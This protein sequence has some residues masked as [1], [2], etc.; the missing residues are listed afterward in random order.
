MNK[1]NYDKQIIALLGLATTGKD[2]N[3]KPFIEMGF[4]KIAF[5]DSLRK[6]LWDILGY[7]PDGDN[8]P[9]NDFK[10]CEFKIKKGLFKSESVTTVRKMLQNTGSVFK[11]LFGQNYWTNL[12]VKTA[13]EHDKIVVTDTR[14][15]YEIKKIM[16]LAKKGYKIN[17]VWCQYEHADY[18][19]LLT[20]T[21]ESEALAQFMYLNRD[22]YGLYDT[23][24]INEINMNKILKDFN[25]YNKTK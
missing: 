5:A 10:K 19:K 2:H 4:E 7:T 22:K 18:D 16:S 11:D 17:F 9:Y 12:W 13:L 14:F 6:V 25:K 3:S 24:T 23:C 1:Q 21:H 20:D 15:D 8:I